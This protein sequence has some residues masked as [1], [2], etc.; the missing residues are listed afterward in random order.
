MGI[1]ERWGVTGRGKTKKWERIHFHCHLVYQK[2]CWDL[3]RHP[4]TPQREDG[5]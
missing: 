3:M 4:P 5:R 2:S 1:D